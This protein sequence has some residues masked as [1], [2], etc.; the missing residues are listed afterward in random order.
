[1]IVTLHEAKRP[2]INLKYVVIVIRQGEDWVLV[3]HRERSTWE[4][5][6]GHIEAG[7]TP[8]EAAVR[9]LYEETGAEE[10]KL[11]PVCIYSVGS[12]ATPESF[13][14][15]YFAAVEKFG[16]LP[17]YEMEERRSFRELPE[18]VTYPGIYPTLFAKVNEALVSKPM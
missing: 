2:E 1:M 11:H 14:M 10:Y 16:P 8:G 5:A 4:F 18:A 17:Q 13:G 15:L 12:E 6:G 3:R 9:E 7:E